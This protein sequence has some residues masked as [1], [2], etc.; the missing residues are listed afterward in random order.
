MW[1]GWSVTSSGTQAPPTLH[2][3]GLGF[4]LRWIFPQECEIPAQI[5]RIQGFLVEA[6]GE[7]EIGGETGERERKFSSQPALHPLLRVMG[8]NAQSG[9]TATP[10]Q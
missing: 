9:H 7:R 2:S 3:A 1:L 10:G 5:S 8:P 6:P 4:I